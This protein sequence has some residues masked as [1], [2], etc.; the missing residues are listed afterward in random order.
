MLLKNKNQLLSFLKNKILQSKGSIAIQCGHF[1]LVFDEKQNKQIPGIYQDIKNKILKE[2][3]KS[4]PYMGEFPLA[5]FKL[6]TKLFDFVTKN[7]NKVKFAFM[8]NDWQFVPKANFG[9]DNKLRNAFYLESNLPKSYKINKDQ[10]IVQ[11]DSEN[12]ILSTLYFSEQKL[13]NAYNH[14]FKNNF[15]SLKDNSCAQE[16]IPFLNQLIKQNIKLLISFIPSTCELAIRKGTEEFTKSNKV[17][18]VVNVFLNGSN[19]DLFSSIV[20][21]V[22]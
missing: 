3:V 15:C 5:T 20:V 8:V 18:K 6:G 19:K 9:E 17:V 14:R 11:K 22:N 12:K 21:S 10:I 16:Y 4:H 13:R 1:A 7:K 2:N